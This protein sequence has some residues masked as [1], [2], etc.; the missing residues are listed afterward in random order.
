VWYFG[1][2]PI[3]ATEELG[4]LGIRHV[5]RLWS[6]SLVERNGLTAR[7]DDGGDWV[8]DNTLLSGLRLGLRETYLYLFVQTPTLEQF[9]AWVLEKNGGVLD[10]R[11]IEYL[12]AALGGDAGVAAAPF[13]HRDSEFGQPP[14]T[15]D[16][17]AFWEENGYVVLH[18][19][20]SREQCEAAAQAI[21]DFAGMDP[22]RP[23]TW[24]HGPQGVSIWVPL[25]HHP[26]IWA[27]RESPR[28]YQAFAQIWKRGD[29]WVSVDQAGFNPPERPGWRFPG[30]NL[31][32]DVSLVLPIPFGVQGIL[33]L[34]GTTAKQ[35]A[36]TC[37]PGFHRRVTQWLKELP[38][39]ADPRGQDLT[40]LPANPIPGSAG[41]L[42]I[43]HHALP[44]G[45]SPNRATRPRIVQYIKMQP[46]QWDFVPQWR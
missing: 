23:D 11:S 9:E 36:F 16:D 7:S 22:E 32:F 46:S 6:R 17:L 3:A 45:A 10:P 19:A 37:V 25:L 26:A 5:K 39:G 14:L 4:S 18:D 35:G 13:R 12:N 38:P 28:I 42:I 21:Y 1:G 41:D 43:W 30:P 24:Y 15:A 29:L 27:N 20:V 8:A 40:K 2:M 44:H 31:H 34:T 33:Y